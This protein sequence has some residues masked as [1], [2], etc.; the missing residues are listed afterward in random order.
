MHVLL[1]NTIIHEIVHK[2]RKRLFVAFVDLI[3]AYDRVNKKLMVY[4]L[5]RKGFSEKVL[6]NIEAMVDN[7][8]QIPEINGR[9]LT[10]IITLLGLK[11]SDNLS[12]MML[13]KSLMAV[14]ILLNS[15]MDHQLT[16]PEFHF[17]TEA[18]VD[19]PSACL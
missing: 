11:H 4:K 10:P 12:L 15:L 2:H 1:I 7:I 14:A 19:F 9:L 3:K 18:K 6:K 16:F 13:K 17:E 8:Y 5:K